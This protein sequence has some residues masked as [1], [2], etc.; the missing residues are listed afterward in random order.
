MWV[1]KQIEKLTAMEG[2]LSNLVINCLEIIGTLHQTIVRLQEDVEFMDRRAQD[3]YQKLI[4][5]IG[6]QDSVDPL[7]VEHIVKLVLFLNENEESIQSAKKNMNF[8]SR[9]S[10]IVSDDEYHQPQRLKLRS[11][12]HAIQWSRKLKVMITQEIQVSLEDQKDIKK[13]QDIVM[14][15]EHILKMVSLKNVILT[16]YND[17]LNNAKTVL[18][19]IDSDIKL[20]IHLQSLLDSVLTLVTQMEQTFQEESKVIN[21]KVIAQQDVAFT[22]DG[23][24]LPNLK[25][26]ELWLNRTMKLG[27]MLKTEQVPNVGAYLGQSCNFTSWD[28]FLQRIENRIPMMMKDVEDLKNLNQDSPKISIRVRDGF[29]KQLS[30]S[31]QSAKSNNDSRTSTSV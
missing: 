5:L 8:L 3:L 12:R 25:E 18:A 31:K 30:D 17:H 6:G 11:L 26:L 22:P 1:V 29:F 10:N 23:F 7:E 14:E 9:N 19:I 4:K 28:E 24:G 21:A 27:Q 15:R 16:R 2:E 20:T 13:T